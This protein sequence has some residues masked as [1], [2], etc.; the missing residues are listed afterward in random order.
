MWRCTSGTVTMLSCC[1]SCRSHSTRSRTAPVCGCTRMGRKLSAARE[2]GVEKGGVVGDERHGG[3]AANDHAGQYRQRRAHCRVAC[4]V[5]L[6]HRRPRP[7]CTPSPAWTTPRSTDRTQ[8]D[9]SEQL[10]VQS[11]GRLAVGLPPSCT[12]H[13]HAATATAIAAARPPPCV[14]C[15]VQ[16]V[17][18]C[19][20]RW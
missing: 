20:T 1:R 2:A 17:Q 6:Q 12:C 9:T 19:M 11:T 8:R 4:A 10:A 7:R 18:G 15:A 13:T 5:H 16:L 14:L 3:E